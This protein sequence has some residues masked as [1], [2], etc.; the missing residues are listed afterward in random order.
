MPSRKSRKEVHGV[1]KRKGDTALDVETLRLGIE[2]CDPDL[3][4]GFYADDATLIIVNADAP[5]FSPFELSGKGEIAKH[6]RASFGQDASHHVE[7]NAAVGDDQVT[8]WETCGYP[9]GARVLVETTLE[10]RDGKIIR[11]V[12]VV[13]SG[14]RANSQ[15]G[16][17][18]GPPT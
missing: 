10:V 8:I 2:R 13:A 12:D 6:L 3:L 14:A 17:G 5:Y 1:T 16:S 9:D 4:L 7:R 11:Q 18:R 15:Q